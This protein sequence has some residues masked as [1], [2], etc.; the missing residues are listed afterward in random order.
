MAHIPKRISQKLQ[1]TRN[2]K[3][4]HRLWGGQL[5]RT[6]LPRKALAQLRRH[7]S[8]PQA[9]SCSFARSASAFEALAA[10]AYSL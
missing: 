6:S 7:L 9:A 8:W 4:A 2:L 5:F 10:A 1:A 3:T